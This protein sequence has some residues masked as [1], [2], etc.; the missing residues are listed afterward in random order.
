MP[1]R[2]PGKRR[3]RIVS[4]R[5][6]AAIKLRRHGALR[7]RATA[8]RP[9]IHYFKR[10]FAENIALSNVA[11]PA[12]WTA[13][14]NSIYRNWEF[15]LND[16]TDATDFTALFA[17]YKL[18]AVKQEIVFSNTNTDDDN[19]QMMLWWDTNASAQNVVGTQNSF[20]HS[21]TS[22][23][24]VLKPPGGS[25]HMYTKLKQLSNTYKLTDDDY[26]IVKP[27]YVSTAEPNTPHYGVRMRLARVDDMPFGTDLDKFQTAKIITTVYLSC[28]KV[29]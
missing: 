3:L 21:Q 11:V 5:R 16:L 2:R 6:M 15:N 18:N 20:L 14:G 26:A 9:A 4:N 24:K 29:H 1:K 19:S 10:S 13:D 25:I 17:Q 22:R 12:N 28:R 23:H 7:Q 8:N 27:R